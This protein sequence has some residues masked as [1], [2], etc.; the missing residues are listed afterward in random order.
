MT[1]NFKTFAGVYV[2]AF[3]A[4]Y[5][6]EFECAEAFDFN[7][8]LVLQGVFYQ[9]EKLFGKSF[10]LFLRGGLVARDELDKFLYGNLIIHS[11]LGFESLLELIF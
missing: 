7:V 2:D 6:D 4:I 3:A 10:N 11:A 8:S 1:L 5:F 9:L